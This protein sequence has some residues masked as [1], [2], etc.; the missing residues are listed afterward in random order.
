MSIYF[1]F[2]LNNRILRNLKERNVGGTW[3]LMASQFKNEEVFD[4]YHKKFQ[5]LT[6]FLMAR[7]FKNWQDFTGLSKIDGVFDV[8]KFQKMTKFLF[9]RNFENWRV[10]YGE[11]SKK[12]RSLLMPRNFKNWGF[13]LKAIAFFI[14]VYQNSQNLEPKVKICLLSK[15][16]NFENICQKKWFEQKKNIY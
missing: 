15:N 8:E 4:H 9:Q 3:I 2:A 13:W 12:L 6:K 16:S 10:F 11:K 14:S 7:T 1:G 5:K